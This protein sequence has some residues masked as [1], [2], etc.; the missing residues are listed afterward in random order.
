MKAAAGPLRF[1]VVGLACAGLHTAI[2]ILS[3]R[4]GIHYTIAA[5]ISYVVVV[6]IG[7]LLH[8]F[9]TFASDLARASLWRYALAMAANYPLTLL[10]LFI[11]CDLA[12]WP[13]MVAAPAA[14]VLLF[15][16]NYG[17]SRRA[18]LR[19]PSSTATVAHRST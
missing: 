5:L 9:F 6:V 15:A 16:W 18:I 11:M 2:M 1:A 19:S 3:D 7:F 4:I 14:T 10:L 17:T 12:G 13:M 8:V